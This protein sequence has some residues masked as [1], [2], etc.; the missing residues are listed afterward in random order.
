MRIANLVLDRYRPLPIPVFYGSL[1]VFRD[2]LNGAMSGFDAAPNGNPPSRLSGKIRRLRS[3][4]G[5][6]LRCCGAMC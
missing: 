2:K 1:L 5:S 4:G 3:G 6:D